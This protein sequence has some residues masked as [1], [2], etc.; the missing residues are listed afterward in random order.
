MA[1]RVPIPSKEAC[2]AWK[3]LRKVGSADLEGLKKNVKG[4]KESDLSYLQDGGMVETKNENDRTIY[5][6]KFWNTQS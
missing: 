3:Y 4:L 5:F 6:Y 2:R 1:Q